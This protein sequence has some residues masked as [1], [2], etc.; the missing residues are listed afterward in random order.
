MFS[1]DLSEYP[2]VRYATSPYAQNGSSS[3]FDLYEDEESPISDSVYAQ[4]DREGV[5]NSIVVT[6]S[7]LDSVS[8][9]DEQYFANLLEGYLRAEGITAS[10]TVES[11]YRE[12]Q[13]ILM[14]NLSVTFN[15]GDVVWAENY[16]A[17]KPLF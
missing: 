3:S 10:Y 12:R 9:Q 5:L 16:V 15:D 2:D 7:N 14:A 11:N 4:F 8:K 17:G 6:Y 13:N 1:L